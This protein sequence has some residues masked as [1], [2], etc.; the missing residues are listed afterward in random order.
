MSPLLN[1]IEKKA[2]DLEKDILKIEYQ[3]EEFL[4]FDYE[5]GVK[6]SIHQLESNLKYIS[7]LANGAPLDK[8]EGRDVMDFLRVHYTNLQKLSILA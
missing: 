2:I 5:K 4:K 1:E 6:S 3:I 8:N 7:I